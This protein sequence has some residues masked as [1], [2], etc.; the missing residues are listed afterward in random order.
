MK[1]NEWRPEGA[2]NFVRPG[3]V[4]KVLPAPGRKGTSFE[5][6][7]QAIEATDDGTVKWFEVLGG[8]KGN[9]QFH[10]VTADRIRRVEQTRTSPVEG[11]VKRER[12]R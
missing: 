6:R 4:V 10:A 5:A 2:R 1:L 3:D 12:K 9:V 7:V 8:K 11:K